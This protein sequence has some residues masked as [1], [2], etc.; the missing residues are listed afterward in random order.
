ML[1]PVSLTTEYKVNADKLYLICGFCDKPWE[2]MSTTIAKTAK[3]GLYTSLK[4]VNYF[5]FVPETIAFETTTF[6]SGMQNLV[7]IGKELQT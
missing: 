6:L 5:Q 7:K 1:F 4:P 2:N 3:I